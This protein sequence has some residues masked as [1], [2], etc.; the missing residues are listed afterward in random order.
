MYQVR[1][2][3]AATDALAEIWLQ[4]DNRN[5]ITEAVNA[6]DRRLRSDPDLV[7]ESREGAVRIAFFPP[8]I[9]RFRVSIEDRVVSVVTVQL[10][11]KRPRA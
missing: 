11:R 1:W 10:R 3:D 2:M 5:A 8:L 7:G 4:S 6:I 9:V